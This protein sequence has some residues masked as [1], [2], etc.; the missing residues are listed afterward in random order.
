[1][2]D[3]EAVRRAEKL[4]VWELPENRHCFPYLQQRLVLLPLSLLSRLR[5]IFPVF[6][7]LFHFFAAPPL[8]D[9]SDLGLAIEQISMFSPWIILAEPP[10][11]HHEHRFR[12]PL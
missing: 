6:Q 4:P 2:H 9:S 12:R 10:L 5:T 3:V 7:Q 1:M 8:R 11:V